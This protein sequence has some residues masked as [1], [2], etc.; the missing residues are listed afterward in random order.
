MGKRIKGK[1]RRRIKE[2]GEI[3]AETTRRD[4]ASGI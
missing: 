4:Q 3:R 1:R 2:K